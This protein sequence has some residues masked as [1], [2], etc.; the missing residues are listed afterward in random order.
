[1]STLILTLF[2]RDLVSSFYILFIFH[3]TLPDLQSTTLPLHVIS[4]HTLGQVYAIIPVLDC[5][6]EC[7]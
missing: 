6:L 5:C 2:D 1:M 7:G 3:V 4:L